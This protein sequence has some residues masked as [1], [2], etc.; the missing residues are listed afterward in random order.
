MGPQKEEG[1][2]EA[3]KIVGCATESGSRRELPLLHQV[4]ERQH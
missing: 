1:G 4:A 2:E 3:R